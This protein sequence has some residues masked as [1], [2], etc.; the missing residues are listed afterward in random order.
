[1]NTDRGKPRTTMFM[2]PRIK[3][4]MT[5]ANGYDF[6]SSSSLA[7]NRRFPEAT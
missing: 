6:G 1:M 4:G 7:R 5:P 3:S 2:D